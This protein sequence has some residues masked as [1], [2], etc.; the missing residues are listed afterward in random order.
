MYFQDVLILETNSPSFYAVLYLKGWKLG[1]CPPCARQWI[2][3]LELRDETVFV[4]K[5]LAVS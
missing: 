5:A 2:R 1:V 4:L 3:L